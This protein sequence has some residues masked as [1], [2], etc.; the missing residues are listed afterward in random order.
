MSSISLLIKIPKQTLS[1]YDGERLLQEFAVSTALKGVGEVINSEKTPRGWHEI[2]AKIGAN[3]PMNTVFI[4]REPTG[5][6]YNET[7]AQQYP[8]RDWILTRILWLKGL[9]KNKNLG[10]DV[11]TLQR[12]IYIHGCPDTMPMGVP[13]SH[14]CIRMRNTDVITLFDQVVVGTKILIT[15][16]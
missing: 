8:Q 9:E 10:G 12:F 5:E 11:D 6:I 2:Y 16:E 14:G 4:H 1:L 13:L 3:C 15:E 7:L